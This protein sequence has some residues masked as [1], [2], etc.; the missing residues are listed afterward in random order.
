MRLRRIG[1][2]LSILLTGTFGIYFYS[3]PNFTPSTI[4]ITCDFQNLPTSAIHK[5]LDWETY[6]LPIVAS[7]AS[8]E[9]L[10]W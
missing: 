8:G 10:P 7:L 6:E 3:T 1:I 2:I 4:L 5:M 9:T